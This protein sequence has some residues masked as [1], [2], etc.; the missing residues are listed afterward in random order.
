MAQSFTTQWTSPAA[1]PSS[2]GHL[3]AEAVLEDLLGEVVLLGGL[4]AGE[5]EDASASREMREAE[6]VGQGRHEEVGADEEEVQPVR[7]GRGD[8]SRER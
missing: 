8:G 7:L 3:H 2:C 1:W 6:D 4:E 5:G